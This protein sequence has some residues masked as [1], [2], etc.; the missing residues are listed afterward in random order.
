MAACGG[1]P[2]VQRGFGVPALTR[3]VDEDVQLGLL[4]Q[5]GAGEGS[6]RTQAGQVQVHEL[7]LVIARL[8][9]AQWRLA[10]SGGWSSQGQG[11]VLGTGSTPRATVCWDPPAWEAGTV[12]PTLEYLGVPGDVPVG[13]AEGLFLGCTHEGVLGVKRDA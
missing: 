3:V 8:L 12:C 4:A 5:E 1:A 9:W 6:H 10:W 7:H 11:D 2:G 13:A